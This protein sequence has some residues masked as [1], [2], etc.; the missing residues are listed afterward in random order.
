[1]TAPQLAQVRVQRR[2]EVPGRVGLALDEEHDAQR[3]GVALEDVSLDRVAKSL[4]RCDVVGGV[5]GG[6]QATAGSR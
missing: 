5:T 2:Q 3:T 1:V 6:L 4:R